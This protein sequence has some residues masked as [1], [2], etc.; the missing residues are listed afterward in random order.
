MELF[1]RG[2]DSLFEGWSDGLPSPLV[3]ATAAGW[4]P[5]L[6]GVTDEHGTG[7]GEVEG[8]G[9][10]GLWVR[11]HTRRGVAEALRARRFYATRLSGLRLDA[12]LGG[13]RMGER[14]GPAGRAGAVELVVDVDRG[15]AWQG[16]P[17]EAQL[18]RPGKDVPD[19]CAVVQLRCGEVSI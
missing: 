16:R 15:P 9:R 14:V 7:W 10:G 1:T 13:R 11:E 19:V 2:A 4:R 12:L 18:L 5:G 3:A 8:R 6:L 17:L